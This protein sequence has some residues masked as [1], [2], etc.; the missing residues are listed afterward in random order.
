MFII[1]DKNTKE[2]IYNIATGNSISMKDL[3]L[4]ILK[5]ANF[6]EY[7]LIEL[8]N[9]KTTSCISIVFPIQKENFCMESKYKSSRWTKRISIKLL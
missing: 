9:N 7:K 2:G 8:K 1:N 4:M 3:A 5:I 6:E